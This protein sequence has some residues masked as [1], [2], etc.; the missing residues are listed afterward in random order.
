V[1]LIILRPLRPHLLPNYAKFGE[2]LRLWPTFNIKQDVSG[3]PS[4]DVTLIDCIIAGE[5]WR[6]LCASKDYGN[7]RRNN[8]VILLRGHQS[9]VVHLPWCQIG[10]SH[11]QRHPL[12]HAKPHIG[13]GLSQV[14]THLWPHSVHFRPPS[15]SVNT[16]SFH[17]MTFSLHIF[18]VSLD[19]E[20]WGDYWA[21]EG[22]V[23]LSQS[24]R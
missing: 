4:S 13:L 3:R 14:G 2:N 20:F 10:R 17:T 24:A 1:I 23:T 12:K 16:N 22:L 15:H 11:G 18:I 7:Y 21:T 8:T 5:M 19:R 6:H 9:T